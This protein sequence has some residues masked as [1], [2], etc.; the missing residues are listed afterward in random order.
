MRLKVEPA[1]YQ[2][3]FK[4]A[5]IQFTTSK[6]PGGHWDQGIWHADS[7]TDGREKVAGQGASDDKGADS[8][9]LGE[10]GPRLGGW[11]SDLCRS[12]WSAVATVGKTVSI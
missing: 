4:H 5:N 6:Y 9:A 12:A 8:R 10:T 1:S 11:L 7:S 3:F 2:H